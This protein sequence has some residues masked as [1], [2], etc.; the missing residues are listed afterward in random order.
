MIEVF[1]LHDMLEFVEKENSNTKC[2][3]LDNLPALLEQENTFILT[4]GKGYFEVVVFN[5]QENNV[6]STKLV[7]W[8]IDAI[9][10][11]NLKVYVL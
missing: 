4:S 1:T 9:C 5:S 7:Q 10:W 11:L 6:C 3:R 8:A 2:L